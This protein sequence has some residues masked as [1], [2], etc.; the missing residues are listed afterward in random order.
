MAVKTRINLD[1]SSVVVRDE[2]GALQ[3]TAVRVGT[4]LEDLS[5]S[6]VLLRERG[7]VS[8]STSRKR[9]LHPYGRQYASETDLRNGKRCEYALQCKFG[10]KSQSSMDGLGGIALPGKCFIE[11]HRF[12]WP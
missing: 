9:E 10:S 2:T 8:L 1:A 7:C 11:L 12:K 5:D 3:N 6:A 4:L